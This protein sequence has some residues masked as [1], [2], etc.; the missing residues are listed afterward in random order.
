M[1]KYQEPKDE[2]LRPDPTPILKLSPDEPEQELNE[3]Q[4]IFKYKRIKAQRCK[5]IALNRMGLHPITTNVSSFKKMQK[6]ELLK[7]VEE[8]FELEDEDIIK[9]FNEV[10]NETI[11]NGDTPYTEFPIYR[12]TIPI[13]I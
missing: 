6:L 3:E 12:Q 1:D 10:C 5:V 8:L 13:P 4:Q 7:I 2:E 11:F 9:E